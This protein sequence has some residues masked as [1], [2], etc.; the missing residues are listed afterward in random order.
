MGWYFLGSCLIKILLRIFFVLLGCFCCIKN[1]CLSLS[2]ISFELLGNVWMCFFINGMELLIWFFCC[3]WWIILW[4]CFCCYDIFKIFVCSVLNLVMVVL[5]DFILRYFLI[6]VY[7]SLSL[8]WLCL[9]CFLVLCVICCFFLWVI[10]FLFFVFWKK[11]II[12]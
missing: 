7:L 6:W 3:N 10:W 4:S 2:L 11:E 12:L 8:C 5:I 9:W 1:I